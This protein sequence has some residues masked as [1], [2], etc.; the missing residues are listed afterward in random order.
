[1]NESISRSI[2]AVIG[3]GSVNHNRRIFTAHNVDSSRSV[4][5]HEYT[6]MDIRDAYHHLFD[7]ALERYNKKQT[8]SDRIIQDYY[9]KIR[10]G[11]QEKPFYEVIIQIGNKDDMNVQSEYGKLAETI[12]DEYMQSFQARNP[13]LFVYSAHLH[14]DEETP[15]LHIDF[16]PYTTNS[17]RGLD[18]RVS[19]KQALANQ[20]FKG[21][22]RNDTEWNQWIL[23]EKEI[24]SKIMEKHHVKWKQL[25]TH[26]QHLN[27]LD[28]KKKMRSQEVEELNHE[29]NTLSST[30]QELQNNI[31]SIQKQMT[32]IKEEEKEF[33]HYTKEITDENFWNIPEPTKLM[34]AK[35]YHSKV[36]I[37]FIT[38]IKK[39]IN[40]MIKKYLALSQEVNQLKQSIFPL[41]IK[42]NE[43]N[44]QID[45][46]IDENMEQKN[47]IRRIQKAIG[48][49]AFN[50]ILDELR[51]RKDKN[52]DKEKQ[53][54]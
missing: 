3:K 33:Q 48:Y 14:M 37:P 1:M 15:H 39:A 35:S 50:K 54:K 43:L 28:Y 52:H 47:I 4:L 6:F 41:K 8:R 12:L 16:I 10:T 7:E 44:N 25:G 32:I 13:N 31:I 2:S 24:L 30:K 46:L 42:V 19:L 20:G 34:S 5:N 38:S 53:F 17:K 11:K 51:N 36:V 29:I 23:S 27:V 21:G 49:Q 9:E 18:T 26:E 45:Y 40:R 22:T